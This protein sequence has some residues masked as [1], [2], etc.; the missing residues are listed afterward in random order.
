[1]KYQAIRKLHYKREK[2]ALSKP[3]LHFDMHN[4]LKSPYTCFKIRL[5]IELSSI[6]IY[7][8]QNTKIK[9]N[10]VTFIYVF[11]SF[12]GGICLAFNDSKIIIFG[13]L[14]L[15]FK[16][17]V[18]SAD[19]LLATVKYK[20][21][22]KGAALDSWGGTVSANSFIFGFGI[23]CFNF[24]NNVIFLYIV[25]LIIFL[26][27]IDLKKDISM[28]LINIL[29]E[30]YIFKNKK[31]NTKTFKKSK[32]SI[33]IIENFFKHG[34]NYHGKTLDFIFLIILFELYSG[35]ILL[36]QYFFYLFVLREL[37]MFIYNII[38]SIKNTESIERNFIKR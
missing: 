25:V 19:G 4:W 21:T 31:K 15:F 20:P 18:D 35:K 6:I 12:L 9:S 17:V 16:V 38:V 33:G 32:K 37:I 24:T 28:Y 30:G 7:F 3:P 22:I 36:S 34:F 23:Y 1:M 29:N 27:S 8:L 14:V 11:L 26:K 2:K 13:I 5:Y 10:D